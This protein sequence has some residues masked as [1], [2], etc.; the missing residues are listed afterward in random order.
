[1]L[2]LAHPIWMAKGILVGAGK[3]SMQSTCQ[4]IYVESECKENERHL[5][6]SFL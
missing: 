3:C 5:F 1:M 4:E 6:S 2:R